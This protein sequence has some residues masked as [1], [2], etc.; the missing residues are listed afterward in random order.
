MTTAAHPVPDASEQIERFQQRASDAFAPLRIRSGTTAVGTGVSG[1]MRTARPGE[2]LVTRITGGPCTVLRSR[3]LIGSGDR[4]LVKVALYGRGRAGVE[5]D[6]RQCLPGPGD[7][8]VYETVR[9][10]E[11]CFWEPFDI[12]VLGIPRALLGPHVHGLGSRTALAVPTDGG[13]RRLAATLLRDTADGLDACVGSGGPHLADALVSVVLSALAEQPVVAHPTDNL[14]DRILTYCLGRLSDPRLAP[15][16]VA[17]AHSISVRYLHKVL[18]QR[19]VTLSSWIRASRLERIRRDLAD[20]LLADRSVAVI[21]ARWGVLDA[22]HLSRALRA[23][24]GQSA[25]EIRRSAARPSG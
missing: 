22:T 9:P 21:A 1:S 15:E 11:L 13:G 14:A 17:R 10:Y 25:A 5:Q 3:S 8:V 6:G 4:E 20:P 24:F 7:L 19:G 16:L 2:V 23:E 18:Q 12:V